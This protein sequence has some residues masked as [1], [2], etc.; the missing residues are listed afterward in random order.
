MKIQPRPATKMPEAMEAVISIRCGERQAKFL[1][2]ASVSHQWRVSSVALYPHARAI[3][4]DRGPHESTC[5]LF[6]RTRSVF[7]L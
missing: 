2:I 3:F 6:L 5:D 1:G 4:W 7:P